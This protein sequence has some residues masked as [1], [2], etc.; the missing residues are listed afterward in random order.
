M[1]HPSP[2]PKGRTMLFTGFTGFIG[3]RLLPRLLPIW[4]DATWVLLTPPGDETRARGHLD[5]I[6]AESPGF[7]G[8]V[9]I[10]QGEVSMPN[11]GMDRALADDLKHRLTHAFHLAAVQGSAPDDDLAFRVN[12]DGTIYLLDFLEQ[13]PRFRRVVY[14]SSWAVA[15][16]RRGVIREDELDLGQHFDTVVGRTKFMAEQ[17]VRQRL[18]RVPAIILRPSL[19]IGDA[20]DG[21]A[22]RFDGFYGLL[23][24][25]GRFPKG[26]PFFSLNAMNEYVNLVPVNYVVEAAAALVQHPEA[27]GHC[28]S[29]ADP[30]PLP[31]REIYH[32]ALKLMGHRRLPVG[33]PGSL[34]RLAAKRAPGVLNRVGPPPGLLR[35]AVQDMRLDTT[36][37]RSLLEPMGVS[38]PYL[39]DYLPRVVDYYLAHAHRND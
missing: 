32:Q 21:S 17:K 36:N 19:V 4:P 16:D 25:L 11:L 38:C 26:T 29:L 1:T 24:Y 37:A 6:L 15:G 9:S 12:V 13:C 14:F 23:D 39:P 22:D 3:R 10:T 31:A 7:S 5:R 18:D 34:L 30:R 28:F 8:E 35:Y 2:G 27:V 20:G 33:L